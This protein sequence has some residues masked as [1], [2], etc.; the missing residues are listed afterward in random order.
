M[1]ARAARALWEAAC[2]APGPAAQVWLHGDLKADNLIARDGAL[3]G[4][5]D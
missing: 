1:D 3:R 2:T 4:V 5:I